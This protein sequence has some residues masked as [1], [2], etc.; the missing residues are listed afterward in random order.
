M[1]TWPAAAAVATA[2]AS[3]DP[4]S[5][6]TTMLYPPVEP[7]AGTDSEVTGARATKMPVPDWAAPLMAA[8]GAVADAATESN[9]P[10]PPGVAMLCG[11]AS[12][13]PGLAVCT[14]MT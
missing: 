4:T 12:A 10:A 1:L 6:D 9:G 2:G 7:E 8:L 13:T 5:T 3:A 11:A 14:T